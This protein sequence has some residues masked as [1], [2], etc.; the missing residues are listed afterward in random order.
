MSQ[1]A[2]VKC[3]DY[4]QSNVD[5]SLTKA[6]ELIGGLSNI[7]KSGQKVLL[8]PNLLMEAAPEAAITTHPAIVHAIAKQ[9]FKLGAKVYATDSSGDPNVNFEKAMETTGIKAAVES[10]GGEIVHPQKSGVAIIDSPSGNK[11]IKKINLI[12]AIIDADVIINLP[13]LKTH[14]MTLYTGAIKNMFGSVPGFHKTRYHAQAM[15]PH[16]FSESLVDVYQLGKPQLTIMD[17]VIGMEG[18][19]PNNGKTRKFGAIFVSTDG[20][21]LDAV[22]S[23]AIGFKPMEIDTTRIAH[24]RNIGR[25]K[26]EEI[27]IVGE[28]FTI[29]DWEKPT[30][31]YKLTKRLPDFI[32]TLLKPITN[33]LRINPFIIQGKCT[34][35]LTCV[36]NCPTKTIKYNNNI[37]KIDLKKCIMCFCCHELCPEKA[38]VLKRSWLTK[39]AGI[40]KDE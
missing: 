31:T 9:I 20:V 23:S 18:Q 29:P 5:A 12:K 27:E 22:A 28:Y 11:R 10:A 34:Q 39:L 14:N 32:Y 36:R 1:V 7:I 13:K 4:N 15:R 19:G 2:I 35:C 6:L 40:G 21:A 24:E 33:Q 38:I 8:K 25:G 17:G 37:V 3:P 26:L 30:N 16:H